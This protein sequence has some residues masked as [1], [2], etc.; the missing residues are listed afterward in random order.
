MLVISL[1]SNVTVLT[2]SVLFMR[3]NGSFDAI[4]SATSLEYSNNRL[5]LCTLV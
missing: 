1:L 5:F 3:N 4:D 2:K